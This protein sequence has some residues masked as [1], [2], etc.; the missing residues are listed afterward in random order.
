MAHVSALTDATFP[1]KV[2]AAPRP[3]LVDFTAEWCGPCRAMAPA[4]EN[5]AAEYAGE[6]DVLTV[7]VDANPEIC[8]RQGIQAVPTFLIFNKG[9]VVHTTMD[10]VSRSKLAQAIEAV[11]ADAR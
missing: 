5:I 4:V 10:V 6:V 8:S 1:E 7:D 9:E 2:L 11:L 3:V